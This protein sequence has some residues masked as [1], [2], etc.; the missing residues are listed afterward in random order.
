MTR[1]AVRGLVD[2]AIPVWNA[3]ISRG[4]AV[5][6]AVIRHWMPHRRTQPPTPLCTC[7]HHLVSRIQEAD[8]VRGSA[9]RSAGT[10]GGRVI[11]RLSC[12]RVARRATSALL[13]SAA[14][15]VMLFSSLRLP[16]STQASGG[17]SATL[18]T[19]GPRTV[20]CGLRRRRNAGRLFATAPPSACI[21]RGGVSHG[22]TRQVISPSQ[23][24]VLH[25]QHPR[26]GR[27]QLQR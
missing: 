6:P 22:L 5:G 8:S 24:R 18:R 17:R 23:P 4:P 3:K 14:R 20:R 26:H 10:L 9:S 1:Y 19:E 16:P 15:S 7:L 12:H 25:P 27:T 2:S 21:T 13:R 11:G